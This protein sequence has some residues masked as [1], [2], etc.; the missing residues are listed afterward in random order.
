[1]NLLELSL[2]NHTQ[3][4][5][6]RRSSH[7]IDESLDNKVKKP[8]PTNQDDI[9]KTDLNG[10]ELPDVLT[11][12]DLERYDIFPEIFKHLELRDFLNFSLVSQSINAIVSPEIVKRSKINFPSTPISEQKQL[13]IK[14]FHRG[15]DEIHF[16]IATNLEIIRMLKHIQNLGVKKIKNFTLGISECHDFHFLNSLKDLGGFEKLSLDYSHNKFTE[17]V[18]SRISEK[19]FEE[20]TKAKS[21]LRVFQDIPERECNIREMEVSVGS[22]QPQEFRSGLPKLEILRLPY[23]SKFRRDFLSNAK[24]ITRSILAKCSNH[25]TTLDLSNFYSDATRDVV[26]EIL[27]ANARTLKTIELTYDGGKIFDILPAQPK[28]LNIID[29]RF[30]RTIREESMFKLNELIRGQLH[31]EMISV[32]NVEIN[33]E[34]LDILACNKNLWSLEISNCTFKAI[35]KMTHLDEVFSRLRHFSYNGQSKF[36]D[37]VAAYLNNVASL[38]VNCARRA[39]RLIDPVALMNLNNLTIV[40]RGFGMLK[41]FEER[42]DLPALKFLDIYCSQKDVNIRLLLKYK[43]ELKSLKM[44]KCLTLYEIIQVLEFPEL[45]SLAFKGKFQHFSEGSSVT[46]LKKIIECKHN[47]KLKYVNVL[48]IDTCLKPLVEMLSVLSDEYRVQGKIT[49]R[50]TSVCLEIFLDDPISIVI[51]NNFDI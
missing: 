35:E 12:F 15:Y 50:K 43:Q 34:L 27:V 17:S 45:E 48:L 31:L 47:T 38:S 30:F 41:L 46:V 26:K 2:I 21:S 10:N 51:S 42:V 49:R 37:F 4:N 36:F 16:G 3:Q 20:I 6:K 25:L 7:N 13:V 14:S 40:S 28:R 1:M 22:Y 19:F 18:S 11:F 8:R 44:R 5:W 23:D 29:H 39:R 24:I 9:Q 32:T 33:Q